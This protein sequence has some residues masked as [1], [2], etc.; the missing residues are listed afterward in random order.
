MAIPCG[1]DE[2]E[3]TEKTPL[4]YQLPSP[5]STNKPSE[6]DSVNDEEHSVASLE[7]DLPYANKEGSFVG[8]YGACLESK[9]GKVVAVLLIL[10]A[11]T[12]ALVRSPSSPLP[13]TPSSGKGTKDDTGKTYVPP[14]PFSYLDPVLDLNL[15]GFDRASD[16]APPDTVRRENSEALPTNQWYQNFLL[17]RGHPTEV[18]RV[19]TVPYMLDVVGPIPGITLHP[20]HI[21][22]TSTVIQLSFVQPHGLSLGCAVNTKHDS[23][24]KLNHQYSVMATTPLGITLQWVRAIMVPMCRFM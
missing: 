6:A 20:N 7:I 12:L 11:T 23:T 1:N 16:S 13:D 4:Y 15:Y 3:A 10:L 22:S 24:K 14:L 9:T 17:N 19:Y 8:G 5:S 2:E 18:T 21:M